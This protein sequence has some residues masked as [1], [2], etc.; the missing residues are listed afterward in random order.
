MEQ[1]TTSPK[2]VVIK[3]IYFYLVCFVALMTVVFS[4]AD[5]INIALKTW[6][7]TKADST[8]YY[9][10]PAMVCPTPVD[11]SLSDTTTAQIKADCE[12]QQKTNEELSKNNR[13]AQ[14][15]SN[16]V[17]DISLIVVGIPLFLYHWQIVRKKNI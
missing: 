1:S 15:Q 16:V 9:Y 17:R 4:A 6:I 5:L 12:R 2:A 8:D 3:T 13:I 10:A 7:F 14:K 11:K